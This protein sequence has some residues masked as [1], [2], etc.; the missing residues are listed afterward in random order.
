MRPFQF[1]FLIF[2]VLLSCSAYAEEFRPKAH[3]KILYTKNSLYQYLVVADNLEKQHR[4]IYN[5]KRDYMQGGIS[6]EN[7]DRLIFEYYQMSFIS[8]AFMKSMPKDVLFVGL[9]AGAMPR[10]FHRYHPKVNVDVVEIDPEIFKV[11][12]DYFYF[13][14]TESLKVHIS[15]G[16]RF[17]KRAKKRY[18]MIFLDAYQTDYIPFHM[19]TVE[20]LR[21]VRK[22]LKDNGVVVSNVVPESKNKYFYSMIKTYLEVFPRLYL[23]KGNKSRNYVFIATADKRLV[24]PEELRDR[25]KG[26]LRFDIDMMLLSQFYGTHRDFYKA[27]EAELLTDDFAPVNLYRYMKE[28]R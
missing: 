5:S 20:F 13:K 12:K 15:D 11:A 9:G 4:Y 8:L 27:D 28:G 24:G 25:A 1:S 2:F 7:P 19:T 6:T 22:V 10:W 17:I 26:F 21:E 16:R 14:E 18:D 3:E 23:F